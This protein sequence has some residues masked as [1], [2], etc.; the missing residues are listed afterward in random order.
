MTR[1]IP[2]RLLLALLVFAGITANVQAAPPP[3]EDYIK[4]QFI[5]DI[6]LSPSGTRL[7]VASPGPNGRV[8]LA[9]MNL[10][11]LEAPKP[12]ASVAN[13][14]IF[15]VRWV[16]D[17]RLVFHAYDSTAPADAAYAGVFAVDRDGRDFRQLIAPIYAAD[18]SRGPTAGR[19]LNWEW[20]LYGTLDDGS[21]DVLVVRRLYDGK[22]DLRERVLSRLN[23][24]TGIV[25]SLSYGA[26]EG[27]FSWIVDGKGEPRFVETQ[28]AGRRLI[29]SRGEEDKAWKQVGDF[30]AYTN[31]GFE[32]WYIDAAGNGY[33]LGS[34]GRDQQ[35]LYRFDPATKQV[36][37]E[38]LVTLRGFDLEPIAEV[39]A[40]AR[41]LLGLHFR[42]EQP[43]THWFDADLR[44][45]Q[46][47]IDAALPADRTNRL[48]C[49]RCTTTR[50]IVVKSSSDRQPGEFYLFDRKALKLQR[51][52]FARPWIDEKQQGRRTF[53]RANARDG[54][55]LPIYVTRPA[56]ARDGEALPAVVLVH[57][58][59][60]LRGHDLQ[61]E[62]WSQFLSSRGYA[63]LEVEYRG[64]TGYGFNHFRAGWKEWGRAMQ[65]DLADAVAWAGQQKLIDTKK[66]CIVGGSYGGYAALMGP[67]R[68]PGV[69]KC[70][71]SFAGVSDIALMSDLAL[72]DMSE[73]WKRYG[74]PQ[75]IGDAKADKVQLEAT[76]PLRQ[77]SKI[78]VPVLLAHGRLD[79][80]VP[81]DHSTEFLAE[82]RRAAVKIEW[83]EYSDEGHGFVNPANHAD[84][85]RK[86]E[87][88]LARSLAGDKL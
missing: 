85:L 55:S 35:A 67:I 15:S 75:L 73:S 64:S 82:A 28:R 57:G 51:I 53:H 83:V 4:H 31:E 48:H 26:P 69:Y 23:T 71:V 66:V 76:S 47:G 30:P 45:L 21:A 16:N 8:Q 56:G 68:N 46:Q 61:W 5:G 88:F 81:I 42:A 60:F 49:G 17:E 77:V 2:G 7:A 72:S 80:R 78:D 12:I 13:S 87:A 54:L 33:V 6:A 25:T 22:R 32:P 11:P 1:S 27:A 19:M 20:N 41:R 3:A 86:V 38:P 62:P 40:P 44:K 70:A 18:E 43:G 59:P 74:M 10:D 79:R 9:V 84:F 24:R 39:D 50:F 29:Y 34:M 37:K 65:D 63:V 14:D 58:G 36:E 52:G